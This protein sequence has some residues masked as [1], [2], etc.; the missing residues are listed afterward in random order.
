MIIGTGNAAVKLPEEQRHRLGHFVQSSF[1]VVM[2][3]F[4]DS[5]DRPSE[6]QTDEKKYYEIPK[7]PKWN[8]PT[9]CVDRQ[10]RRT[11]DNPERKTVG[12]DLVISRG[13]Q[14]KVVARDHDRPLS[15]SDGCG[16]YSNQN[17]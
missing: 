4:S 3:R 1:V 16:C 14:S 6:K 13:M 17:D 10:L 7:H 11:L 8:L 5:P 9:G 12:E 15:K 2:H